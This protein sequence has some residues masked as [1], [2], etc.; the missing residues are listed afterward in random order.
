MTRTKKAGMTARR[1]R[2]GGRVAVVG[3]LGV[4]S[5]A[6]AAVPAYAKGEVGVTAPRTA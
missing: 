1:K 2:R 4:A 5:L 3:A 6:L